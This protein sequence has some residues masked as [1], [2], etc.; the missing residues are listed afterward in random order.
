MRTTAKSR[1]IGPPSDTDDIWPAIT[2]GESELPWI[3][4]SANRLTQSMTWGPNGSS[5]CEI[6][7]WR[8]TICGATTTTRLRIVDGRPA[9]TGRLAAVRAASLTMIVGTLRSSRWPIACSRLRRVL[10][11]PD[12][13]DD[14]RADV[15]ESIEFVGEIV[16]VDRDRDRLDRDVVAE[17]VGHGRGVR[18]AVRV[19]DVED[20][21]AAR[22]GCLGLPRDGD[23]LERVGRDA[24]EEQSVVGEPV[25]RD[26]GGRRRA[27][28][29]AVGHRDVEGAQRGVGRRRAHDRVDARGH[30]VLDRLRGARSALALV[31]DHE[32]DGVA[33]DATG[34]VDRVDRELE[35]RAQ[36]RVD[37]GFARRDERADGQHAV[38]D[39]RTGHL[40]GGGR[41]V[42]RRLGTPAAGARGEHDGRR[43]DRGERSTNAELVA[44]SPHLVNS[45]ASGRIDMVQGVARVASFR[46]RD[47]RPQSSQESVKYTD[48]QATR[49]FPG[50]RGRMLDATAP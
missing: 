9:I 14:L 18:T 26:R 36:R 1:Q 48:T 42:D 29:D 28:D 8:S 11:A 2:E 7:T 15:G 20:H 43:S 17:G 10:S 27:G 5:S 33:E 13:H 49:S 4:E 50:V 12:R 46:C 31:D 24:A 19:V 47:A 38:V 22:T 37:T 30:Q 23:R 34:F 39:T 25:E 3:A 45:T 16:V 40:G 44:S 6:E 41:D 21:H 32:L 35:G